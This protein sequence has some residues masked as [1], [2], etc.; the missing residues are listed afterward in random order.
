MA[1]AGIALEVSM[2]RELKVLEPQIYKMA[3]DIRINEKRIERG[4]PEP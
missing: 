1:M 2:K 4:H 3:Q